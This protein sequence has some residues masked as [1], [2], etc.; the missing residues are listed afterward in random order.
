MSQVGPARE[1]FGFDAYSPIVDAG[2]FPLYRV[3]RDEY[4]CF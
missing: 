2:P 3:L 1:A 4:P